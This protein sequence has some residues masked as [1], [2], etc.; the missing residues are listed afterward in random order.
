MI[1]SVESFGQIN[2]T[3]I[4]SVTS[5]NDSV[6]STTDNPNSMTATDPF[7]KSKLIM[8]SCQKWSKSF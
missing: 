4:S 8:R 2:Y 1:Y 3:N 7:S 5:F 6:D